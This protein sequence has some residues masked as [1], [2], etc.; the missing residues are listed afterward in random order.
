MSNFAFQEKKIQI[1]NMQIAGFNSLPSI[2]VSKG[3]TYV[4]KIIK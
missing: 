3:D 4:Q 2:C 1:Q